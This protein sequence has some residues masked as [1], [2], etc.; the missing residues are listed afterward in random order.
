MILVATLVFVS[1]AIRAGEHQS[2]LLKVLLWLTFCNVCVMVNFV[3]LKMYV[4]IFVSSLFES[5]G[6]SV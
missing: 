2:L 5:A 4:G 6:L 3:C 1:C